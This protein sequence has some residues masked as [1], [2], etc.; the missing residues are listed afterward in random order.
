MQYTASYCPGQNGLA[1]RKNRSL[2]EMVEAKFPN[3]LW[4]EAVSTA[5][6]LQT[7]IITRITGVTLVP[8]EWLIWS[9]DFI[10]HEM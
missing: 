10:Y 9:V 7:R 5:N 4:G 1:E 2:I 6:Y 3:E 8:I